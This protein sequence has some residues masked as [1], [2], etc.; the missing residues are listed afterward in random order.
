MLIINFSNYWACWSVNL[1]FA[2][3]TSFKLQFW[4]FG[5]LCRVPSLLKYFLDFAP[6][7]A[8]FLG[9]LPK[10]S[11]IW[12]KWSSFFPKVSELSFLGL[13]KSS[14]VS[15]SKVMQAKDHI[16]AD[17]LYFEP[18]KTSGPRYC[19][20]WISVAKW[21]CYQQALPKSAILTL[22]PS[23]SFGPLSITSLVSKA[24]N[25]SFAVLNLL[26]FLA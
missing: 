19:R 23:S 6:L 17:R 12:A 1:Y 8:N 24:E 14:P 15:I 22:N 5:I 3:I 13:N 10:S 26:Y 11:I 4:S 9:N 18:V 21:W 7:K 20:V 2:I 25:N 16:S